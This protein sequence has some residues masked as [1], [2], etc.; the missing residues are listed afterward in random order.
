[1]AYL[2]VKRTTVEELRALP[3]AEL[4]KIE[5][6]WLQEWVIAHGQEGVDFFND[7]L[8]KMGK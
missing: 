8:A 2:D 7:W 5:L 3:Q 1:M 6:S 4:D